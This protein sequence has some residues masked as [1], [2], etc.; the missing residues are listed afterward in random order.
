MKPFFNTTL[1]Y[2][3]KDGQY[4][5]LYRNKKQHDI[6]GGKW[7]GVGGKFEPGENA[8]A[9]MIREVREETGLTVTHWH[10]YGI[11]RFISDVEDNDMYLFSAD[12]FT[13][14]IDPS[15][16]EGELHWVDKDRV[17]SLPTWEGDRYFLEKM[18]AGEKRFDLTLMYDHDR[19]VRIAQELLPLQ[20]RQAGAAAGR[21]AAGAPLTI[22]IDMDDTIEQLLEA[23]IRCTNERYGRHSTVEDVKSWNVTEAFP[24][25]TKREVYGIPDE[26]GFWGKVEPVPGAVEGV[27]KLIEEGHEVYIVTATQYESLAEKMSDLLFKYFPFIEWDH[28]IITKRKQMIRGDVLIDDG[29]HNLEGGDYEKILVDAPHNR[30]YDAEANGMI[31]VHGW[32]EILKAVDDI[33]KKRG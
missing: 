4:L 6:N 10:F 3:E 21:E 15:C 32:D 19:L 28:V 12:G 9:C 8:E 29:P 26:P 16:S 13:G 22:L 14:T 24:G 30:T 33:A 7:I 11:V 20:N 27:R 2:I 1:C 31:R 18:L 17:L 23:W 5:M 25:L